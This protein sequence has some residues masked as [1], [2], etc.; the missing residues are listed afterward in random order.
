MVKIYDGVDKA[1]MFVWGKGGENW[2]C[3]YLSSSTGSSNEALVITRNT[4]F[5]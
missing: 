5:T 4:S 1:D 3:F 2:R